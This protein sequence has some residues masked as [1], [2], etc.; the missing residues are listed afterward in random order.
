M[1]VSNKNKNMKKSSRSRKIG[2]SKNFKR[3]KTNRKTMKRMRGGAPTMEP[4]TLTYISKNK[5]ELT[6]NQINEFQYLEDTVLNKIISN[7]KKYNEN[8]STNNEKTKNIQIVTNRYC[9]EN[10]ENCIN[11]NIKYCKTE[12]DK[13]IG[14]ILGKYIGH[15]IEQKVVRIKINDKTYK[16]PLEYFEFVNYTE[17]ASKEYNP[18]EGKNIIIKFKGNNPIEYININY[19]PKQNIIKFMLKTNDVTY[20]VPDNMFTI[21]MS[22]TMPEKNT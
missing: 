10:S 11:E 19:I 14:G 9:N 21:T 18:Y 22:E 20:E 5:Y 6:S 2:K 17:P 4:G 13:C 15:S 8:N 1:S 3:N 16:F 12:T 7:A